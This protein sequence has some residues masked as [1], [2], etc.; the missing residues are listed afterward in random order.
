MRQPRKHVKALP[1]SMRERKRYVLFEFNSSTRMEKSEFWSALD[2]VLLSLY[3]SIGS[4]GIS[5]RPV[6]FYPGKKKGIVACSRGSEPRLRVA[7]LFLR[8]VGK[9]SIRVHSL[10]SS[11]SLKAL[12]Q[13]L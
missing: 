3:G 2:E 7:F 12:Q 10:R 11:G 5:A 13:S 8:K 6:G 1:K 9:K 4:A